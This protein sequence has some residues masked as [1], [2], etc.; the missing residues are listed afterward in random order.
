MQVHM[1]GFC[2]LQVIKKS[3]VVNIK[4]DLSWTTQDLHV[5]MSK[6]AVDQVSPLINLV[7]GKG[8]LWKYLSRA[9]VYLVLSHET[10]NNKSRKTEYQRD[11]H[12]YIGNTIFHSLAIPKGIYHLN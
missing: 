1:S 3:T 9:G 7:R 12:A 8:Y 4:H 11:I 2:N 5:D 6:A 10:P